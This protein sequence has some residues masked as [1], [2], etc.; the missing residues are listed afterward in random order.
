MNSIFG[1][2]NLKNELNSK[3]FDHGIA[4]LA[5]HKK[6]QI[7]KRTNQRWG[8]GEV[9]FFP[10]QKTETFQNGEFIV[11]A[12]CRID[13]RQEIIDEL[14]V[15]DKNI[16]DELIILETYKKW[17]EE[18][19][20]HL[21]GDFAFAIWNN[22]TKELFCAR[23]HFGTKPLF[24]SF[25]G[26]DFIF[27]SEINA[28]LSQSD[29]DFSIDEQYIADTLS[30][31]KS[32]KNRTTYNEIKKLP[33][34]HSLL[35]KMKA[36]EITPYWKLTPQKQLTGNESDILNQ[37]K[38]ILIKSVECR[39]QPNLKTGAEL[40][41]GLDSSSIAAIASRFTKLSTFSHI[42]PGHQLGK[43]HPFKDERKF[44]KQLTDYCSIEDSFFITSETA[45]IVD[46]LKENVEHSGFVSQQ[47]F[48]T[49]SDH[50]YQTAAKN[51][52]SVLL[53]G[54]SGD[55]VITSK[56][57]NYLLELAV[58]NE[59]E[60][61]KEDLKNQNIKKQSYYR[62]LGILYIKSRFPGMYA[63]LSRFKNKNNWWKSKYENLAL[64]KQ[65][66]KKWNIKKRY[67]D[68]YLQETGTA[69]QS[70]NIE[71][72]THPHVAQRLEYSAIAA[73]KHGIEYRYPFLDKRLIE[74]YL[75]MPPRL[76]ARNG[77]VR[78]AI[79][80]AMK[81]ILPEGIRLRND[82]SGTTIPTVFM[83]MLHD[84]DKIDD[85]LLRAA[86]NPKIK[87]FIDIE[88]LKNWHESLKRRSQ[89]DR[90]INPGAFYNYLKLILFIEQNPEL[91][92]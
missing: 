9:L 45:G 85:I 24:Y 34:A 36:L 38:E 83:R 74:F 71:R 7:Q 87:S 14:C 79:R 55:E 92:Q 46:A 44:I 29:L 50:L 75:S 52:I 80:E 89:N 47:N 73:R 17:E 70:R 32:E 6:V 33:P 15:A 86:K 12:D 65:F 31:I 2:I 39:I 69:L 11:L 78:Y 49:F 22:S 60:E 10:S 90:N 53:S 25:N 4:S 23:D 63:F 84:T 62:K 66:E 30:I 51:S 57:G 56:S 13:N 3:L 76:K 20:V 88:L 68:Y 37:F 91:F 43:I 27:S 26:E 18:C 19:P 67:Y 77:I 16:T 28:I 40:S 81:E 5:K 61:I 1:R 82:K 8:F 41:G 58:N 35:F 48:A 21:L 54:F 72:I 64:N 59:W 42:L